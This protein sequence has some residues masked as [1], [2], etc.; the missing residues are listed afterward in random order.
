MVIYSIHSDRFRKYGRVVD[1]VD[2]STYV[3]A[4]NKLEIPEAV[5]YQA[6]VADFEALPVTKDVERVCYGELPVQM[7]VCWGHNTKLNA[8]EYHRSSEI[9]VAA[10]EA[11]LLLGRQDDIE[12]D[13]TYDTAKVEAFL[14]P[15]GVAVEVYATTLHYA[16]CQSTPNGFIVGIILPRGTN[17]PLE[18][19]HG[20]DSED[21]MITAKNKWLI[22]HA[23]GGL[24]EGSYIGLKGVNIDI[25]EY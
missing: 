10:T 9:N 21:K 5:D 12:E 20:G 25:L 22:G 3:D 8:L 18:E 14:L 2:F 6:S 11:I 17:W 7:G 13:G 16:P 1:N 24:P 19:G 15:K 4:L 23:E